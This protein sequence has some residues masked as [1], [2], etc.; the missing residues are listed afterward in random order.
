M[1][2]NFI[3]DLFAQQDE[4]RTEMAK[5]GYRRIKLNNFLRKFHMVARKL[6]RGYYNKATF[7]RL[8]QS[9]H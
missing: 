7:T 4:F 2:G 8:N 6:D 5:N 1:L 3:L 9:R